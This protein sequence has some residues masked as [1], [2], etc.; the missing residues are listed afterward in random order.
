[1]N[2]FFNFLNNL[3][4]FPYYIITPLPYAIGTAAWD[5]LFGIE[6]A[7][8]LN[9]KIL[10]IAPRYFQNLLNYSLCNKYLFDNLIIDGVPQKNFFIIKKVFFFI[11][12]IFFIKRFLALTFNKLLKI[13]LK[14]DFFFLNIGIK[15]SYYN[16]Q[17]H[18][19]INNINQVE[20]YNFF[21]FKNKIDLEFEKN[22][23]CENLIKKIGIE[24]KQDF[25]CLHVRE[26]VYRND[27]ERREYRN[28][29]IENHYELIKFLIKKNIF[30]F[31]LGRKS[32][33]RINLHS[34]YIIDLPF[35]EYHYDFFDLFLIRN[36]KFYIGDQSGP[37]D[38]AMLFNKDCLKVNMVRLFELGPV[39]KKSRS[40][41]KIPFEKK[42]RRVLSLKEYIN[43][44]YKHHH[45]TYI[46]EEIDFIENTSED[47]YNSISEY[48][49]VFNKKNDKDLKLNDNQEYF[50]NFMI[51]CFSEMY[52][53]D[54]KDLSNNFRKM[55]IFRLLK[56]Q[57][58]SFC[59]FFLEK[60]FK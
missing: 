60:Y 14:E 41:S 27:H 24:E 3:K 1:M 44:P 25:I 40:I 6:K 34:K 13:K 31:R 58:G 15:D 18:K 42:N 51:K 35:T 36:C 54:D 23:F 38:T 39:T 17:N 20:P 47:L 32:N 12:I 50:N 53:N 11:H 55:N 19:K 48:F 43:L 33:N 21:L 7:R 8:L 49:D 37:T 29:S 28:S 26:N 59:S 9:K 2:F 45:T 52:F 22:I 16:N 5:I 10:I 56:S 30:I 46:N 57:K 4:I